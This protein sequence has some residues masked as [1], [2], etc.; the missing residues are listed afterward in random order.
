M[1]WSGGNQRTGADLSLS[2][3]FA[4]ASSDVSH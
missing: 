1:G 3:G 4:E 2:V